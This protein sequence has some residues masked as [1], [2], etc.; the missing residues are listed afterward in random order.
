MLTMF[1]GTPGAGKTALM[2]D[3]LSRLYAGRPLFAFG[4]EGLKLEHHALTKDEVDRWHEVLPEGAVLCIDEAQKVWRPTGPG[5]K[6]P[7]SIAEIEEHR[8]RGIDILITTQGPHLVHKN[9]RALVG[10]H[11]HIRDVGALGR[12]LYEWPECSESIAWRSAP[13]KKAY[14]LPKRAF[15]LYK[16]SSLH[17]KPQRTFPLALV[18]AVGAVL[19]T[20]VGLYLSFGVVKE[21]AQGP[22]IANSAPKLHPSQGSTPGFPQG[23]VTV[24]R[25]QPLGAAAYLVASRP[26]VPDRPETA[27]MY[28]HLRVVVNMPR[29]MGGF[30]TLQTGCR[31]YIQQGLTAP[32]TAEAC[33]QWVRSPPFDP[34]YQ[35]PVAN[36]SPGSQGAEP[37]RQRSA[38]IQDN[39]RSDDGLHPGVFAGPEST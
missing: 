35:P 13:I 2:V 30:C 38:P 37:L 3:E 4:L 32:I 7:A 22:Q 24:A 39:Q 12:R 16:S 5:Q 19:A 31:C 15:S 36:A 28:D 8:H 1:T 10:R 6:I 33:A 23:P 17:V 29:I 9:V 26:V 20:L 18:G 25:P 21:R 14:K 11:V 27:P 34:Y